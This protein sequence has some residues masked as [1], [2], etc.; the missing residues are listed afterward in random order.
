ME[1]WM[2]SPSIETTLDTSQQNARSMAASKGWRLDGVTT[3]Y[4][5]V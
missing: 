3:P 2:I 5:R 4:V 1:R